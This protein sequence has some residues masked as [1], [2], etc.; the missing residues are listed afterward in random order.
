MR[1]ETFRL[2]LKTPEM[3]KR[4]VI[5]V[6][7]DELVRTREMYPGQLLPLVVEP[8]MGEMNLALW[9]ASHRDW[10]NER[11]RRHGGILF[12]GFPVQDLKQFEAIVLALSGELAEYTYRSTPRTRIESRIYTSTEYPAHQTIPMHNEN[13]YASH[14]PMKIWFFCEQPADKG[15]QTPIAD[16]RTVLQRIPPEIRERFAAKKVMYVRN[17][18]D[19]IDLPWQTVFQ[20]DKREEVEAYCREAPM[21]WEWLEGNH[22]RTRQVCEAIAKHPQTGEAVWF[23]QAHLF[24]LSSLEP[25]VQKTLLGTLGEQNLPRQTRY[26]DGSAIET[27]ALKEV[28]RAFSETVVEFDWC[29]RDLLLLDNMLAAHGRRPFQGARSMLVAMAEPVH[30]KDLNAGK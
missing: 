16:S 14:W 2:S 12:R 25:D 18:C 6:D 22:L 17:Y 26:G 11:V 30:A 27:E 19:G 10:I 9:I 7:S 23:N 24:H 8:L 1:D 4:K 5:R 21:E 13:S 28:R 29:R 3:I 15:G 20:T